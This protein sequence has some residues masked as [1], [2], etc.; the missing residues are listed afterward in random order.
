MMQW[1]IHKYCSFDDEL[2]GDGEQEIEICMQIF[3]AVQLIITLPFVL[4]KELALQE[5]NAMDEIRKQQG[6]VIICNLD[7]HKAS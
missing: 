6:N 5:V 7:A 3:L 1:W 2:N 4:S